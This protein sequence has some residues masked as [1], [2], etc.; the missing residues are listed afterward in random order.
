[1]KKSCKK[2]LKLLNLKAPFLLSRGFLIGI[3][4]RSYHPTLIYAMNLV[5]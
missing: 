3:Y 4:V 5:K 2:D 1:M